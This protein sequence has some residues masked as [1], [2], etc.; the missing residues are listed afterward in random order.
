M[1]S[2]C[3]GGATIKWIFCAFA[4]LGLSQASSLDGQWT[5]LSKSSPVP[6]YDSYIV[7]KEKVECEIGGY[8][9]LHLMACPWRTGAVTLEE[10]KVRLSPAVGGSASVQGSLTI[11]SSNCSWTDG[12]PGHFWAGDDHPPYMP[13]CDRIDFENGDTWLKLRRIKQAKFQIQDAPRPSP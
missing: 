10:T 13:K 5:T 8:V 4:L 11:G 12:A 6:R 2:S 7:H 9:N 3:I 1:S